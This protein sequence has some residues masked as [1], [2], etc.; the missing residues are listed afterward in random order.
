[1]RR[2]VLVPWDGGE[3]PELVRRRLEVTHGA[4]DACL[5]FRDAP[6][7]PSGH[8]MTSDLLQQE[9]RWPGAMHVHGESLREVVDR[10][11]VDGLLL[12]VAPTDALRGVYG[13]RLQNSYPQEVYFQSRW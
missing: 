4:P 2:V 7:R 10:C 11:R 3:R 9:P 8:V 5:L 12:V 6:F 1:M 13:R